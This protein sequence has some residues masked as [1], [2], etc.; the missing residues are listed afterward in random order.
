[1]IEAIELSTGAKTALLAKPLL[2]FHTLP[3]IGIDGDLAVGGAGGT[4]MG[5]GPGGLEY[6]PIDLPGMVTLFGGK[7]GG[8]VLPAIGE[9]PPLVAADGA[10]LWGAS[11]G[12]AIVHPG[13]PPMRIARCEGPFASTVAGVSSAGPGALVV[14]CV[15]GRV[16]LLADGAPAK[17]VKT[18][19]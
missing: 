14:A 18:K 11:E 8:V 3:A 1:L 10:V 5:L 6:G 13:T 12:V 4:L 17:P 2:P 7:D 15:D 19:P 9:F 16:T